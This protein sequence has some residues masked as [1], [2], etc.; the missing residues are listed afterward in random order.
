M[1]AGK[2]YTGIREKYEEKKI[3]WAVLMMMMMM[4]DND[5]YDDEDYIDVRDILML[6]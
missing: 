2:Q 6:M 5:E 1:I 3:I 4:I